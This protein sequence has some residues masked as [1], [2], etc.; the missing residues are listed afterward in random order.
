M[1]QRTAEKFLDRGIMPLASVKNSDTVK[2]IR[3]QSVGRPNSRLR[4][5]WNQ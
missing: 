2:L 5:R 4:A 3:L 1:G